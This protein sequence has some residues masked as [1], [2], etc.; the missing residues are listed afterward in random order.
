MGRARSLGVVCLAAVLILGGAWGQAA[1]AA[2]PVKNFDLPTLE[3]GR[4]K[5]S[6][7]QGRVVILDFFATWCRPCKDSM[8]KLN[9]LYKQ[10]KD[11]G[12]SVI[13]FSLDREGI[14][15]VRPYVAKLKVDFPIV[16]GDLATA[17]KLCDVSFLPTT[18]VL[19][20]Q[21]KPL[22]HYVGVVAQ[23]KLMSDVT[24]LLKAA[25]TKQP[26][27]AQVQRRK[28]GENR[29]SQVFTQDNQVLGGQQ[30]IF[31]YVEVDVADLDPE[32]GLWLAVNLQPEVKSD[33]GL[34]KVSTV[35]NVYHRVDDASKRRFILFVGCDSFP[36]VPDKGH[37]RAWVDVLGP[38]KN[39]VAA[40]QE[41]LVRRPSCL[42]A[43]VK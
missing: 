38:E 5:L 29:F 34:V 17:Q 27:S 31:V 20:L 9:Q 16:I 26:A 8:A 24:P 35:K 25:D 1:L 30:G 21:G 43:K 37:Y 22:H 19:D 40:S 2:E 41:F 13:G 3:G 32:R 15:V 12:L 7:F 14:K 23:D 36:S 10:H 42:T 4:L 11:R 18:L 6:D 28:E 39:V 33:Q